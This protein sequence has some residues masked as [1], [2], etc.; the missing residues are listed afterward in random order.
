MQMYYIK[1]LVLLVIWL[2]TL[3]LPYRDAAT[4]VLDPFHSVSS[5]CFMDIL[6]ITHSLYHN[7]VSRVLLCV[8]TISKPLAYELWRSAWKSEMH[9]R[10][11]FIPPLIYPAV[12]LSP[13][14]ACL[15][16]K[17]LV[18]SLGHTAMTAITHHVGCGC[19]GSTTTVP[20]CCKPM[21]RLDTF[22]SSWM[23]SVHQNVYDLCELSMT[24][25]CT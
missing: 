10:R 13:S 9:W 23:Q 18:L 15:Q 8:Q 6:P 20:S 11:T 14:N 4:D 22:N 1:Q 16:L 3:K 5:L 12:E 2:Q 24:E 7:C 17:G 25:S 21:A 19:G